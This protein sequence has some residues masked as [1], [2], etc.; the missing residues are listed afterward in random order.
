[1]DTVRVLYEQTQTGKLINQLK[2]NTKKDR[3]SRST[4]EYCDEQLTTLKLLFD[5]FSTTDA[6]LIHANILQEARQ[7][8][9]ADNEEKPDLDKQVAD[10]S[11]YILTDE[12]L[13]PQ[14]EPKVIQVDDQQQQKCYKIQQIRPNIPRFCL[15]RL[16]QFNSDTINDNKRLILKIN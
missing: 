5:K 13:S 14:I 12:E 9:T 8:V 4:K 1:M 16:S 2:T 6:A 11:S 15:S 7:K 10:A 3:P